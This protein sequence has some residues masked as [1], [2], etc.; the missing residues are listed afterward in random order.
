M[1]HLKMRESRLAQCA[2]RSIESRGGLTTYKALWQRLYA[3]LSAITLTAAALNLSAPPSS[4]FFRA[5]LSA[6]GK[7]TPPSQSWKTRSSCM[8]SSSPSPEHID[9]CRREGSEQNEY[10][11]QVGVKWERV[12]C[13]GGNR[14]GGLRL[15]AAEASLT[16]ARRERM[17]R[18]VQLL[19]RESASTCGE[20]ERVTRSRGGSVGG[21]RG[22]RQDQARA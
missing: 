3:L 2:C 22:C 6:S 14:T 12:Q 18:H 8:S 17:H 13:A 16:A 10:R 20:P 11:G 5:A 9:G 15:R 4:F 1:M 21:I 7:K 19:T